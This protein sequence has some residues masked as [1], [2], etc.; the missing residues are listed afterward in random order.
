M[1]APKTYRRFASLVLRATAMAG[2]AGLI[3]KLLAP[4]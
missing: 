3:M 4:T 2:L 1:P